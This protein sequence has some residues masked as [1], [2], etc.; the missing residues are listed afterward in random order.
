MYAEG[1]DG[2]AKRTAALHLLDRLP[3]R[4]RVVPVQVLGELYR[5]LTG[6]AKL[7]PAE[8]RVSVLKWRNSSP[9][10]ETTEKVMLD[11]IELATAHRLG[12]WDSVIVAASIA[13]GC[14]LLLSEDMQ[15]GFSWSG[16]TV[17]NP[18]MDTVH[19]LLAV[20]LDT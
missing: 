6:K 5:V 2:P 3:L 13:A 1:V 17:V 15:D 8:A 19:P 18:M 11:A 12:I 14:Q 7:A 9:V 20:V 10:T 16:L 4:S